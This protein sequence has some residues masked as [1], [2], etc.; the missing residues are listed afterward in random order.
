[1]PAVPAIPN[2]EIQ[3]ADKIA[4]QAEQPKNQAAVQSTVSKATFQIPAAVHEVVQPAFSFVPTKKKIYIAKPEDLPAHYNNLPF[5]ED[6]VQ[7]YVDDFCRKSELKSTYPN[8]AMT[9]S[10]LEN[11]ICLNLGSG[12]SNL[13]TVI[14]LWEYNGVD[15]SNMTMADL[16][17]GLTNFSAQNLTNEQ[18]SIRD[19]AL[20]TLVRE[21]LIRFV[22]NYRQK[23]ER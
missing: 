23:F 11:Q 2:E 5:L 7:N 21:P 14:Y 8:P 6:P 10:Y 17:D 1:M 12:S 13:K 16:N 19:Q 15:L 4:K 3:H 22:A 18:E 9:Y 20:I